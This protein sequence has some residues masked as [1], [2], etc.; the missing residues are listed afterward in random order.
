MAFLHDDHKAL[1][2]NKQDLSLVLL[3]AAF[4][5]FVNSKLVYWMHHGNDLNMAAAV[6]T[7]KAPPPTAAERRQAIQVPRIF[8]RSKEAEELD[9]FLAKAGPSNN[10]M[11]SQDYSNPAASDEV[12]KGRQWDEK[13]V[14]QQEYFIDYEQKQKEGVDL[15]CC[16]QCCDG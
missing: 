13:S 14:E 3:R 15:I 16:G 11:Y 8:H 7:K 6:L 2:A 10:H 4:V 5:V 1:G 12:I 9:S